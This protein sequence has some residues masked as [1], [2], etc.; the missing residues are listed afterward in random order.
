MLKTLHVKNLALIEEEEIEFGEGLNIMTGETGAGKSIILGALS[1]ALGEK[2]PKGLLRNDEDALVEAVF[3]VDEKQTERLREMEIEVY[4]GEVILSRRITSTRSSAKVNGEAVPAPVLKKVSE[5][6]IDIYGQSEHEFLRKNAMHL[7]MI[8]TYASDELGSLISDIAECYDRYRKSKKELEESDTAESDRERELSLLK[9]EVNEIEEAALTPGEDEELEEKFSVAK[10]SQRISEALSEAEGMLASD[11]GASEAIGRAAAAMIRAAEYDSGLSDIAGSLADAESVVSDAL[12]SME[13]YRRN[14]LFDE[15]EFTAMAARLD[16]INHLKNK[17][18][19][20]SCKGL[21]PDT[22][23]AV[24]AALE[25]RRERIE[26]L[27]DYDNYIEGLK[28]ELSKLEKELDAL[29]AKASSIR[30]EKGAKLCDLVR[31]ALLDLNFLDVRFQAEFQETAFSRTGRD[32]VTF[33][34]STNPGSPLLPLSQ[35]ASGGELSRI[36]LALKTVLASKEGTDCM[37][38]DE[39]DAGISGR[40]ASAVAKRLSSVAADHQVICITHLPQIAAAGRN[41]FL[42]E[43]SATAGS[44]VSTIRPLGSDEQIEEIARLVGGDE[45]TQEALANARALKEEMI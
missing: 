8:D 26:K 1:L 44:T 10:N 2:V 20:T 4:D 16:T 18:G 22:I 13:D 5:G 17:Y 35:V 19:R 15:Q 38:F 14:N 33:L 3:S 11:G 27:L 41:H 30:K 23:E 25:E 29:C 12:R 39:I 36:M 40:T 42:I 9:H 31:D 7:A 21:I 34:I 43:K 37:I 32:E 6:L 24:L 45:L 28:K